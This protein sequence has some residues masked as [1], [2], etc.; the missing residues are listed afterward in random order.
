MNGHYIPYNQR[1]VIFED[2]DADD[3]AKVGGKGHT[4]THTH[5]PVEWILTEGGR[6]I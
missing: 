3:C 4:Y 6:T 1:L 5:A 2:F